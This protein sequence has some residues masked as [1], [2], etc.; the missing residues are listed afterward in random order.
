M[1]A[2]AAFPLTIG[3]DNENAEKSCDQ[4]HVYQIDQTILKGQQQLSMNEKNRQIEFAPW[5]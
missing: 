3:C 5:M 1:I 2:Q 4:R